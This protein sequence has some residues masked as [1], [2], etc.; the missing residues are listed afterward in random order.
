MTD[1]PPESAT[2]AEERFRAYLDDEISPAEKVAF[3]AELAASPDLD[4]EFKLY[5]GTVD[6]LHRVGPIAA[7][8]TLLPNIE[9]RLAGRRMREDLGPTIRFPYEV[10]VF[11]V[12]LGCVFYLYLAHLPGAPGTIL[13]RQRPQTV[14]IELTRPVGEA[15]AQE[16]NLEVLK[17]TRPFE[18]TVFGTYSRA[19][20]AR[21]LEALAPLAESLPELPNG[22]SPKV[23]VI[24]I[25]PPY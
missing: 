11:T 23:S 7:P 13:P 1:R 6:L 19:E 15:L 16:F 21:L 4:R 8:E 17:T 2:V 14:E 25:S 12:M 22:N 18:R 20:A 10:L 3:E 9:R 5:R 24:L